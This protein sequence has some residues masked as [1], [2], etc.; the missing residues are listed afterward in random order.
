M[1][2]FQNQLPEWLREIHTDLMIPRRRAIENHPFMQAMLAG[3]A[4]KEDASRYFSGLMWHLLDFGKHVA[5]LFEKRPPEVTQFLAGRSEDKDGDTDILART[6]E[7]FG[8]NPQEIA[9]KPW[10][11]SPHRVWV[12]H[13][14]LLRSAIYS[15]DFSWQVGTAALNVGIESLVPYMI[16]PLF[17]ASVKNYGV[18]TSNAKWLESRSG[19]EEK[20]HGENGYLVLSEFVSREDKALQ[21]QCSFYIEALSYSMAFGLLESGLPERR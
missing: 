17:K 16:E 9:T 6:V 19:E 14:A 8:G 4:K 20:Q 12:T 13:D 11:Y 2:T 21:K 5:H 7:A 10:D 18:S 3:E 1:N 15:K